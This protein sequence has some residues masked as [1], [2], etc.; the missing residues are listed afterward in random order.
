M[1]VMAT[2]ALD[3]PSP[4]AGIGIAEDVEQIADAVRGRKWVDGS[5]AVAGGGLDGLATVSDPAGALAQFGVAWLIE[6]VKPLSEAL[7]RLAGDPSAISGH[8]HTWQN[9]AT[10]LYAE[11]DALSQA[12]RRETAQW[13]GAAAEAY[14]TWATRRGQ[15][16]RTLADAALSLARMAEGAGALIGTVRLMVRDA[17]ATVVARLTVY[18]GEILASGGLAAPVVAAQVASL[19]ASW[20][21]RIARWLRELIA[22]LRRL[23]GEGNRLTELIASL[24]KLL[25]ERRG[26][27]GDSG[28]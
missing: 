7:D 26:G 22:T 3:S 27:S 28:R 2:S 11:S 18:A 19:C 1:T 20:A 16:V 13:S 24:K 17:I 10:C 6:H 25:A 8:A 4:W 5:L 14:R 21:A 15:S 9:V 23:V 12:I